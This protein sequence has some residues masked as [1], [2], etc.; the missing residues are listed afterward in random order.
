MLTTTLD[1]GLIHNIHIFKNTAIVHIFKNVA[2]GD[3]QH[4]LKTKIYL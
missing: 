1:K 4:R 2:I 3:N